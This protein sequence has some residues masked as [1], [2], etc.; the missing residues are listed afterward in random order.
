M[1]KKEEEKASASMIIL[2]LKSAYHA[3]VAV[4]LCLIAF[5]AP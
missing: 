4:K 1:L 2:D 3:K 5:V